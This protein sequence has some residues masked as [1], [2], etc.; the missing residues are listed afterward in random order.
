VVW[1]VGLDLKTRQPFGCKQ[2]EDW[3]IPIVYNGQTYDVS[4]LD[5]RRAMELLKLKPV[6]GAKP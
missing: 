3:S 5:L 6:K 4:R 2:G 1:C